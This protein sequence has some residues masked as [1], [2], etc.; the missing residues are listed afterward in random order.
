MRLLIYLLSLVTRYYFQMCF[1]VLAHVSIVFSRLLSILTGQFRQKYGQKDGDLRPRQQTSL[2]R[3]YYLQK[4]F[5][6]PSQHIYYQYA[7][8][9]WRQEGPHCRQTEY[10]FSVKKCWFP[11]TRFSYFP[12]VEHCF[13]DSYDD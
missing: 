6:Y 3:G 9:Y 12:R 5:L 2:R 7:T 13:Y 10:R 1:S 11:P 4:P 8:R